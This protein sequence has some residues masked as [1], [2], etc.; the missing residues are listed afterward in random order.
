MRV[1]VFSSKLDREILESNTWLANAHPSL[2][3][4]KKE[5]IYFTSYRLPGA[6]QETGNVYFPWGQNRFRMTLCR[7]IL[8][9]VD[10]SRW[11]PSI[12]AWIPL[13][14]CQKEFAEI[15]LACDP[16]IVV[17]SDIRWGRH[18][19]RALRKHF[20]GWVY[21]TEAGQSFDPT[22]ARRTYDPSVKVSIVLPTYNGSKYI[23]QSIE[24]CLNQTFANLELLIVDDGSREDIQKIVREYS[25]PR[26]R[27]F[28]HVK[29]MGIAEALNTGFSN[30]VGDYLTW[31]SDDNYYADNAIEEMVRF[32]QTYPQVDFMYADNYIV[33]EGN[34]TWTGGT[35][36]RTE[37]MESLAIDNFVGACFLYTR[38]VYQAIGR[39][40]PKTFLA[41]DYD[42][43]VRVSK[44]F[45][46]QRMFR[47][48]Y[49]YRFHRNSLTSKFT[50]QE[51]RDKVK[52]VKEINALP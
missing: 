43:W 8:R 18:F 12:V 26:L 49:Y 46:M 5:E 40:N 11:I 29:N 28:R 44:R 45:R 50:A 15:I 38:A 47:C 23:R 10:Q 31:T 51:V 48:L 6:V 7:G 35:V 30:S 19:A 1:C 16:D 36:R 32:L 13:M 14:L 21:L 34:T 42:Y 17:L 27:Y 22:D 3:S 2:R 25:D 9:L 20:P 33:D 41:E 4:A 39:Y 37:P 52:L 24:S